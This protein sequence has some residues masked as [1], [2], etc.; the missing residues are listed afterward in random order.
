M[1]MD[2]WTVEA[3]KQ[4]TEPEKSTG[5]LSWVAHNCADREEAKE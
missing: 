1:D 3:A 4:L 5:S 2:R